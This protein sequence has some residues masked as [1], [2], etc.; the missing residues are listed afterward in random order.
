M[1]YRRHEGDV[2]RYGINWMFDDHTIGVIFKLPLWPGRDAGLRIRWARKFNKFYFQPRT[3]WSH[4]RYL[5]WERQFF[6]ETD[7]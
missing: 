5:E 1:I 4:K 6:M 7:A 3:M 2:I